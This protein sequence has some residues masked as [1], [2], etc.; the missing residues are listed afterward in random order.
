MFM[1]H[2]IKLEDT[3]VMIAQMDM[4]VPTV[5]FVSVVR[6]LVVLRT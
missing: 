5:V 3:A 1:I 2:P 4:N 6:K